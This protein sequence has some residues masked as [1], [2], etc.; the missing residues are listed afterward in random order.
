[1]AC[2]HFFP[3]VRA[4][5]SIASLFVLGPKTPAADV[6]WRADREPDGRLSKTDLRADKAHLSM[7]AKQRKS[8]LPPFELFWERYANSGSYTEKYSLNEKTDLTT[9]CLC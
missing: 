8:S 6:Y 9:T 4:A 2:S 1:M 5:K 3:Q 7:I